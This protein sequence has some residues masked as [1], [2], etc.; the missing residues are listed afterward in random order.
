MIWYKTKQIQSCKRLL[1][2]TYLIYLQR[3]IL[4]GKSM[5]YVT[6]KNSRKRRVKYI[7]ESNCIFPILSAIQSIG[8]Q[9]LL[10]YRLK[11]YLFSISVGRMC[12]WKEKKRNLEFVHASH[13]FQNYYI[14][15]CK[16]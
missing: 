15:K 6:L 13:P 3:Y 7:I 4:Q 2:G 14:Q 1:K 16:T 8:F 10:C 5:V 11:Y 9:M 12:I